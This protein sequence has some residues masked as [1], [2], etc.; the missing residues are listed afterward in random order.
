MRPRLH[1]YAVTRSPRRHYPDR[2][3][4]YA[5]GVRTDNEWRLWGVSDPLWGVSSSPGRRRGEA[6]PWTDDEFYALGDDWLDFCARWTLYGL[7]TKTVV[8]VGCGA[9]RLT[10]RMARTFNRVI[11][12]DVSPGML[13]YARDRLPESNIEWKLCSGAHLPLQD[14]SVDAAFSCHVLQHLPDNA[15]QLS[16]F[17]EIYRVLSPGGTALVHLPL[18]QFP[19]QNVL[20]TSAARRAYRGYLALAAAKAELG[21]VLMGVTGTPY[22]LHGTSFEKKRLHNDLMKIGFTDVEFVTFAV[23]TNGELHSCVLAT[24]PA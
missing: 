3:E 1:G 16:V 13:K 12:C 15:A 6:H 18:H 7:R 2:I 11:G 14:S 4:V 9:G 10:G 17:S 19:E 23:R 24:K 8:E 5:A 22:M 21:R 20:F